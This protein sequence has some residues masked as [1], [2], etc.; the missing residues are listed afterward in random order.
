[1]NEEDKNIRCWYCGQLTPANKEKCIH[2]GTPLLTTEEEIDIDE[3]LDL[4]DKIEKPS[5]QESSI[6]NEQEEV[7]T[8]TLSSPTPSNPQKETEIKNTDTDLQENL[9][10]IMDVPRPPVEIEEEEETFFE[11]KPQSLTPPPVPSITNVT[12]EGDKKNIKTNQN[13]EERQEIIPEIEYEKPTELP[14]FEVPKPPTTLQIPEERE[15]SEQQIPTP[16]EISSSNEEN[17]MPS[18]SGGETIPIPPTKDAEITDV[19]LPPPN[20]QQEEEHEET[21]IPV[22]KPP[23]RAVSNVEFPLQASSPETEETSKETEIEIT[24]SIP[25]EPSFEPNINVPIT[26]QKE[27]I[28]EKEREQENLET[29]KEETRPIEEELEEE[30]RPKNL[31]VKIKYVAS[32]SIIIFLSGFASITLENPN[33]EY[34]PLTFPDPNQVKI[35][36]IIFIGSFFFYLIIGYLLKLMVIQQIPSSQKIKRFINAIFYIFLPL[37]ISSTIGIILSILLKIQSENYV[38]LQINLFGA[39]VIPWIVFFTYGWL[40]I[41]IGYEIGAQKIIDIQKKRRITSIS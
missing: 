33:Y 9:P 36:Q 8:N 10:K 12:Q 23:T 22:P 34:T 18:F 14:G 19:P 17:I 30:L 7:E 40:G 24:P 35:N 25:P 39:T 27:E 28:R 38:V 32:I 1:M 37:I 41:I 20:T 26:Q 2:C 11:E 16:P 3:F 29:K 31:A 15:Q 4:V 21:R 6:K 5:K 13:N